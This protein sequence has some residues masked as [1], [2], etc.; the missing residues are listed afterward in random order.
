M[1]TTSRFLALIIAILS[2]GLLTTAQTQKKA[3]AT[4]ILNNMFRVYS[5]LVSYQDE[6]L[7]VTTNDEAT[8]GT[9]EKM[10]FKTFFKRPNLFRFEWTDFGITKLGRT[11]VIWFNGS[12]AFSYW[13]PDR[14]EKEESL[15]FAVAGATGISSRTVNTVFDLL[16][17]DER[18][19][20]NLKM[21]AKVSLLGEEVF[22]GVRCYRIKA[23]EGNE[24]LELWVGKNDYLLRKLRREMKF[25]D[26][27]V[28]TEEIRKKIQ[29]DQPISEVVF[30]YKPPIVLTPRK[31][32]DVD[33]NKLLNPG[34]PVWSEFRSEEGRFSV[35][36]PEK[37]VSQTFSADTPQGRLEHHT[38][39]A[40]HPSLVCM[41]GYTDIP[42][43]LLVAN[44]ADG[45][46]NDLRDQTIKQAGGKLE[47]ESSLSLEGHPGREIKVHMFRGE[48]RLQLFLVG[49]RLYIL[50]LTRL[51]K[52][53]SDGETFNKFFSSFK[54][55]ALTKSIA[56]RW[57]PSTGSF[58]LRSSRMSE[59]N[60]P[61]HSISTFTD[62]FSS[63]TDNLRNF[64]DTLIS[65]FGCSRGVSKRKNRRAEQQRVGE[66]VEAFEFCP[67]TR[68][69]QRTDQHRSV[70]SHNQDQNPDA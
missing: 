60:C 17:P 27:L 31:D 24:P 37:P 16:M 35:L 68:V 47:S 29:V 20:S 10:P 3:E 61:W 63:L 40:S 1:R 49:D 11:K 13:E 57:S 48:L 51:D 23:T 14:Y 70:V 38:F 50:S 8:G 55:T 44:N 4:R 28:I 21:L 18:G 6:G 33:L 32:T 67:G 66:V 62:N 69:R 7:L 42:K 5:R 52:G 65:R 9:I 53:E 41:V 54:L 22:E 12:E 15:R 43:Q 56:A 46:F 45:F 58:V 30:N 25:D 26:R 64:L 39:I 34:P 2:T 19:G 36:V 59:Y